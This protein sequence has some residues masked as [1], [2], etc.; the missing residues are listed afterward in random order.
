MALYPPYREEESH[1]GMGPPYGD[2]NATMPA[3]RAMRSPPTHQPESKEEITRSRMSANNLTGSK[4]NTS[5]TSKKALIPPLNLPKDGRKPKRVT[6]EEEKEIMAAKMIQN[7]WWKRQKR[8]NDLSIESTPNSSAQP[9]RT[10]PASV[11]AAPQPVPP[12][13][14]PSKPNRKPS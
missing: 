14:P 13:Y 9:S 2:L 6:K 11:P 4:A 12:S 8:S 1:R 10:D 7:A 5:F 3:P